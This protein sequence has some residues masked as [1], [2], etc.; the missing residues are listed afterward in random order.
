M[1]VV[2]VSACRVEEID[3]FAACRVLL[4]SALLC[5][6]L[7]CCRRTNREP[8]VVVGVRR[9]FWYGG[10]SRVGGR[11]SGREILVFRGTMRGRWQR[12]VLIQRLKE[13]RVSK[14][15]AMDVGGREGRERRMNDFCEGAVLG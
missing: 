4:C 13:L 14:P 8:E 3:G 1:V 2:V 10:R 6:A 11:G 15:M 5:S 7:L 12:D 9:L